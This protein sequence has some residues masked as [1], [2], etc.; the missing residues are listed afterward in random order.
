MFLR[1]L[2]LQHFRNYE[3]A[4]FEFNPTFN[5]IYGANAQ[6][7]TSVL[8]A[9]YYLMTGRSFRSIQGTDLIK[10]GHSSF[11]LEAQF[12]KH[13]VDQQI[14]IGFDGQER[15]IFYNTT[16]LPSASG[17]FGL[18]SGVIMTPHDTQLIKGSPLLRRQFLDMQI[19]QID[20]FYVHQ[21]KRY[22][23]AVQQRNRL[24]K[25][26]QI[27]TI[28][29]WEQ[30]ICQAAAYLVLKRQETVQHLQNTCQR[31]YHS[32]TN[33]DK[34]L[35]IHYKTT[36]ASTK[37]LEEIKQSQWDQLQRLRGRE[38]LLGYTLTGP[39][40]DDLYFHLDNKDI[41]HFASEGQQRSCVTAAR[42][43]E[44]HGLKQM[45]G[46]TPLM[47]MD[48]VGLGLDHQR[49]HQLMTHLQSCGQ[50]FLTTTD[51]TLLDAFTGISKQMIHISQGQ[52]VI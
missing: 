24:L 52:R 26:K 39:H 16:P 14:K 44:W 18:L 20:P 12:C 42:F 19:A 17:L 25:T 3:E 40:K 22:T 49:R 23:K 48:D 47:M 36:L 1:S 4:Y 11:Y 41:R 33:E 13:Q 51:P 10:Q 6:G 34:P 8:E 30:E 32:L 9:I 29:S 2:Y 38:M 37:T 21:L 5:L 7:K 50:V 43:A 45:G 27:L 15:R 35:E 46:V 31:I 28:Q